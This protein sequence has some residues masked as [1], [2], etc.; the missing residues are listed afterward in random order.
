MK[1]PTV[2]LFVSVASAAV[3][4]MLLSLIYQTYFTAVLWALCLHAYCRAEDEAANWQAGRPHNPQCNSRPN[5]IPFHLLEKAIARVCEF[6]N[7][8]VNV[9]RDANCCSSQVAR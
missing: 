4:T 1:W 3:V 6:V 8:H 9:S 2:L 5:F 7:L